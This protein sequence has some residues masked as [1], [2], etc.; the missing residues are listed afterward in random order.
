MLNELPRA[1]G[2]QGFCVGEEAEGDLPLPALKSAEGPIIGGLRCRP[3]NGVLS[4]ACA[5]CHWGRGNPQAGQ[6]HLGQLWAPSLGPQTGA[7]D[8]SG[9]QP[10]RLAAALPHRGLFH[11]GPDFEVFVVAEANF[12]A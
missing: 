8:S 4:W 3:S 1:V 2:G 10:P 11:K 12:P 7:A 5:P 9:V 6:G